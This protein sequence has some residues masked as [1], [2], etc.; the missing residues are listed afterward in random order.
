MVTHS[1]P[2]FILSVLGVAFSVLIMFMQ[3][4]FFNGLNDSQANLPPFFDCDLIMSHPEKNHLKTGEEFHRLRL[5]QAK[6]VEGV[7]A[8]VPLY[9]A[10]NY[11]WNPQDG[12][13][14]RLLI[15]GV[16]LEDPMLGFPEISRFRENLQRSGTI[17]FDRLSRRELGVVDVGTTS[18]LVSR[19]VEVVGLFELG[20]NITYEGHVITSR[21]NFFRLFPD[22]QTADRVDLGLIRTDPGVDPESVRRRLLAELPND[23]ILLTPEE[24][25]LREVLITTKRS[26]SGIVFGIGLIVG[27]CIGIIICYQILFNEISD[28]LSQF[29]TIKAMGHPRLFLYGIVM[30]EALILSALGFIP[31]LAAGVG[32]YTFLENLTRISMFLTPGRIL[33]V[34]LLTTGMC[35]IAA[36]LS[37]KTV[38]K[39]DPADLY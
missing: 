21:E 19:P 26:P 4:G 22:P 39:A 8:A 20:P 33:L 3:L 12:S 14:N 25:R 1:P 38:I 6:S 27:F 28:N 2:R 29:A 23:F 36:L 17:L 11:W 24:I 34:L 9:T 15:L 7:D 32:L 10:A 30:G 35:L 16:D 18:R 5:Q 37:L 31:G 13:R